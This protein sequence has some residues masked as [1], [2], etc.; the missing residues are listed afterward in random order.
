M[1]EAKKKKWYEAFV[2]V[3]DKD[4]SETI[5]REEEV[6][7]KSEAVPLSNKVTVKKP[8]TQEQGAAGQ[9]V[10][11][12][13]FHKIYEAAEIKTPEHGYDIY[14][15]M[16]LLNSEDLKDMAPEVKKSAII[17]ALK[18]TKVD[19]NDIIKDAVA[20]DKALD[21]Y[22]AMKQKS[23]TDFRAR[24]DEENAAIQQEIEAFVKAKQ[25]Q[26][27]ANKKAAAQSE[28]DLNEW[29]KKKQ[30]EEQRIYDAV[31]FFVSPN[32]ITLSETNKK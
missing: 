5:Q 27:E 28:I 21:A 15:V 13:N 30:A 22:E 20:R 8:E 31:S 19:V 17:A 26:I 32:P 4:G 10:L 24:K 16:E 7:S 9:F 29:M 23:I 2:T 25:A 14:K 6:T 11:T 1:A 12:D 3:T 18:I